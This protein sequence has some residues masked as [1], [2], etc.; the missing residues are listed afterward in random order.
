ME[1]TKPNVHNLI[2]RMDD[3]ILVGQVIDL[4]YHQSNRMDDD[5]W[6][7]LSTEQQKEILLNL[8]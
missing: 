7:F 6:Q 3:E 8:K 4:I 5:L 2:E 1:S